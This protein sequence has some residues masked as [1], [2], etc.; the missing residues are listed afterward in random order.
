MVLLGAVVIYELPAVQ[1][2]LLASTRAQIGGSS[3]PL[4]VAGRAY[5]SGS[6]LRAA[7]VT[8]LINFLLGSITVISLPSVVLPGFG[9][10]TAAIRA[11]LWGLLLGPT[12]L[13]T[14]GAMLPH[15]GTILLEG[16]GYILAAFFG[17]LIPISLL[18][19]SR[20]GTARSR[21]GHALRLNVQANGLVA[22]V[23]AV[24]AC[25]EAIAVIGMME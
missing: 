9:V 19:R 5:G 2:V 16:E 11:I 3:G 7:A 15:T 24:A 12:T 14:A 18:Q 10:L 8:F 20:G 4:A 6:I 23:L 1:A 21:F 25:Y 17:L 22:L 13:P